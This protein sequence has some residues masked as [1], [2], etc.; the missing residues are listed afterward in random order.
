MTRTSSRTR[1][2]SAIVAV[3]WG[4]V[5]LAMLVAGLQ[6]ISGR[7]MIE[8]RDVQERLRARWAARAGAESTIAMLAMHTRYPVPMDAY[9]MV[10]D[11]DGVHL[12]ALQGASWLIQHN[13]PGSAVPFAGPMDEHSR[14]NINGEFRALINTMFGPLAWG[15][16]DAIEDWIDA[17]DDPSEFGVERD[18]YL[19]LDARYEPRNA[20]LHTVVELE[21]VAGIE[22]DEVRGEDWNQNNLLDPEERDGDETLPLDDG[23]DTLDGG[24]SAMLTTRSVGGGATDSGEPRIW[25]RNADATDLMERFDMLGL[26]LSPEK[27]DEI[28]GMART[29]D[30]T[31]ESLV[32]DL[33]V[34]SGAAPDGAEDEDSQAPDT[35]LTPDDVAIL[36]SECTLE[37]PHR[38]A[39][40]RLNINTVPADTLYAMLEGQERLVESLLALRTQRSSGVTSLVD[41]W[42]LPEADIEGMG[43]LTRFFDTRSNVFTITSRGFSN[44]T[45]E[46]AEIVMVVDRSTLPVRILDVRED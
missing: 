9:A 20:P 28:I 8:G 46:E 4:L 45:G 25:L 30:F 22:P 29:D 13:G 34:A 5:V 11:L 39:I 27:A 23:S 10:R 35:T 6:V 18:Y 2:G 37:A 33:G 36:L 43:Q 12:G 15:V 17:D 42:S 32:S 38:P 40:G 7:L 21:L 24:W 16:F 31:L 41:L 19:S 44:A 1:R 26:D 14:L 3:I